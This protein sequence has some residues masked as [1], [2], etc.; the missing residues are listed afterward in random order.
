MKNKLLEKNK[1]TI[2]WRL[3]AVATVYNADDKNSGDVDDLHLQKLWDVVDDRE[4][5]DGHDVE[6]TVENLSEFEKEIFWAIS[7]YING[8]DRIK[9]KLG[10]FYHDQTPYM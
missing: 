7:T 5:D 1:Q 3:A 8:S 9:A 10:Y 2:F 6:E 4:E